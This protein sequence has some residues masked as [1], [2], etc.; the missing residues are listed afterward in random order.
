MKPFSGAITALVTPFFSDADRSIDFKSLEKLVENQLTRKVDGFVLN[1]T[2]GESPTLEWSEVEEIFQFVKTRVPRGFPLIV[3]VGSSSTA[4]TIEMSKKA[5]KLGANAL[6]AVVPYYNKPTQHGLCLHFEAVA[7]NVS[8]PVIVYNVPS[9]TVV[10][11]DLE[12]VQKLSKHPNIIG[13]KE[14]SGDISFARQ[15]RATCGEEFIMLSGDDKTYDS[16]MEVGGDGIISVVS[17]IIPEAI[18]QIKANNYL[19]LI[20]A[21]FLE[22]SPIG[23]KMALYL[24][25]IIGDSCLR[26]PLFSMS[27]QSTEKLKIEMKNKGLL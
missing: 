13:I 10:S 22:S 16:F 12:V 14:A 27:P 8:T 15:I 6:L 19:S 17:H 26:S 7:D 23:I 20:D 18:L 24:L 25:G 9:R 1:G 11:L 3:G 21:V 5:Q 4:K 2:T